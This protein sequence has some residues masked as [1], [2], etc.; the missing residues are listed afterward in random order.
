MQLDFHLHW[1]LYLYF[2]THITELCI[3]KLNINTYA[4]HHKL[5]HC[6][7]L[8]PS[9]VPPPRSINLL[10]FLNASCRPE[11]NSINIDGNKK[12]KNVPNCR[13]Q[14]VI[15]SSFWES[16]QNL[17]PPLRFL[18]SLFICCSIRS[19]PLWPKSKNMCWPATETLFS[20]VSSGQEWRRTKLDADTKQA[21]VCSLHCMAAKTKLT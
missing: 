6:A 16:A 18:P 8:K 17:P 9:G 5:D 4:D 20:L 11:L 13:E 21:R 1:F 3:H 12:K 2:V 19:E 14:N 10:H 7:T 15:Y